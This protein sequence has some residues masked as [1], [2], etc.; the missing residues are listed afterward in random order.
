VLVTAQGFEILTLGS[1][2]RART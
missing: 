2:D 1:A